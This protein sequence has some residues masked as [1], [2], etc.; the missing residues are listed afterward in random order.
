MGVTVNYKAAE[1]KPYCFK[2]SSFLL[3]VYSS[4]SWNSLEE[5]LHE[6][7]VPSSGEAQSSATPRPEMHIS[8]IFKERFREIEKIIFLIQENSLGFEH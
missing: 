8:L 1:L 5:T 7:L 4:P 3:K 6:C 2:C